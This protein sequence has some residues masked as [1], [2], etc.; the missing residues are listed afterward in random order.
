MTGSYR[1]AVGR[2]YPK[3][4]ERSRAQGDLRKH[5]DPLGCDQPGT[6]R[7][8]GKPLSIGMGIPFISYATVA[9]SRVNGFSKCGELCKEF[10]LN[11][12][13]WLRRLWKDTCHRQ[14]VAQAHSFKGGIAHCSIGETPEVPAMNLPRGCSTS[15]TDGAGTARVRPHLDYPATRPRLTNSTS[16]LSGTS[17]P[18]P[19]GKERRSQELYLSY[20][21]EDRLGRI[22]KSVPEP[23]LLCANS[24][25]WRPLEMTGRLAH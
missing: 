11:L 16:V 23:F 17:V 10:H 8:R 14:H 21:S 25:C 5:L 19:V 9:C 4:F 12:E 2:L 15:Q 7:R 6:T 20:A 13:S 24:T 1:N 3:V 18:E 22:T